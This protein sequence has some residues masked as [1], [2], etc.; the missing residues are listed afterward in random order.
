MLKNRIIP[1]LCTTMQQYCV[2][3]KQFRMP[4]RMLGPMKQYTKTMERRGIDE[5]IIVDIQ[6]TPGLR[7]ISNIDNYIDDLF[8]PITV[9]GGIR[10]TKQI[11]EL[12]RTGA[13]KVVI[14]NAIYNMEGDSGDSILT[15]L[16]DAAA[17][18]FG[19]QAITVALD[20]HDNF[21][22]ALYEDKRHCLGGHHIEDIAKAVE[23]EGAGEIFLTVMANEGMMEGYD[24]RILGRVAN[25]VSIPVIINGGC[26]K[27]EH[28]AE[29]LKSGANA[30]AAGSMFLFTEITPKIC[31]EYLRAEG[32]NV[33]LPV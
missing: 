6:A 26:G 31:A 17:R 4:P 3:P 33:R 15:G 13:D 8:C 30:V 29:A 23:D 28:M 16:I 7:T 11:Q 9:G 25:S 12:L 20:I 21:V 18:R 24:L 32:F 2:K 10:N 14:G 27:P 5:L 1:V 22:T 19:S